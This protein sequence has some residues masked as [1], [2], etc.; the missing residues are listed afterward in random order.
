MNQ[1]DIKKKIKDNIN[2]KF[3]NF[4][5]YQKF[6]S[7]IW[8][9]ILLFLIV[10]IINIYFFTLNNI[11]SFRANW[12]ENKCN[13][14]YMA[15]AGTI[16]SE[17]TIKNPNL[18]EETMYECLDEYNNDIFNKISSPI[19]MMFSIFGDLFL[20]ASKVVVNITSFISYLFGF[21]FSIF[22]EI[23]K[24][25]KLFMTES[26][27]IVQIIINF[28]NSIM[29]II[30]NL[31][32]AIVV[33]IEST[34]LIIYAGIVSFFVLVI[35]PIIIWSITTGVTIVI[36]GILRAI[37]L[38]LVWIPFVGWGFAAAAA[39]TIPPAII[40]L[41]SLILAVALYILVYYLF[42]VKLIKFNRDFLNNTKLAPN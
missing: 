1:E 3:K 5:Y 37:W 42:Y 13:P 12:D 41:I 33:L 7:D 38:A 18:A 4:S 40:A 32:Y 21:L 39:A 35:L 34:K 8:I 36:L 24:R 23:I 17:D 9:T 16:K 28:I 15:L 10:L 22:A 27:I 6:S 11:K 29:G 2:K 31:Y 20:S 26:N 14:V 30:T 19:S 25:V